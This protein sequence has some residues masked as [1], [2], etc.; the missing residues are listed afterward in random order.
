MM[1]DLQNSFAGT[2]AHCN[3]AKAAKKYSVWAWQRWHAPVL[4]IIR[5]ASVQW[6]IYDKYVL[7]IFLSLATMLQLEFF[8]MPKRIA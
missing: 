8:R 3:G 7:E 1:A 4:C 6:L 5:K 2:V